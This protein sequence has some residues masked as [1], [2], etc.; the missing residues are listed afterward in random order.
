MVRVAAACDAPS[1]ASTTWLVVTMAREWS[2]AR[3]LSD[4]AT[5]RREQLC[6]DMPSHVE[7][8]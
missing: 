7:A 8:C 1:M 3:R 2:S 6:C 4:E 5:W